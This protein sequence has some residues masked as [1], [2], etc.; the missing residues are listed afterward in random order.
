LISQDF[1]SNGS[2]ARAT[3]RPLPSLNLTP[4]AAALAVF[5]LLGL[6]AQHRAALSPAAEARA[7]A[8]SSRTGSPRAA[9]AFNTGAGG[10]DKVVSI[11]AEGRIF[12]DA[13]EVIPEE[14]ALEL[15]HLA[16][17]GVKSV[18]IAAAGGAQFRAVTQ[19]VDACGEAGLAIRDVAEVD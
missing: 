7:D 5:L 6:A 17:Q 18:R 16:S 15:H 11:D 13:R 3:R 12:Y 8:P 9:P 4:L 2:S 10:E 19:V 14:L 1:T